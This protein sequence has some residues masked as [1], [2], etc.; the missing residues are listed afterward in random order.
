MSKLHSLLALL[1]FAATVCAPV[2]FGAAGAQGLAVMDAERNALPPPPPRLRIPETGVLFFDDFKRDSIGPD[3]TTD[4]DGIWSI[5]RGMLRADMP[6][7]KDQRSL[8]RAGS[9]AWTDYAIDVD[10]CMM[11]G[12]EKGV[13]VRDSLGDGMAAVLR[14]PGHGE[15]RMLK[16]RRSMG[17]VSVL[18][19]NAA[20]YHLRVEVQGRSYRIFVDQQLALEKRDSRGS[21]ATGQIA[22]LAYTGRSASCTVYYDNVLVT[23][24]E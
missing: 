3:W 4:R 18:N 12:V 23:S 13:V 11:R 16:G 7:K 9:L 14:G 15:L 1:C 17:K 8:I 2:H 24:L 5:R 19:G 22:L 21:L 10:V 20:W 6:D